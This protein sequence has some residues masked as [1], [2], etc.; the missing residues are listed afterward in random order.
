[1]QP[2]R[3]PMPLSEV[4]EKYIAAAGGYGKPAAL[5]SLG[6]SRAEVEQVFS[7]YDEDYHISRFFHFRNEA[8]ESYTINEFPQTHVTIDAEI[9]SI[10]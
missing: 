2:K 10:L 8:G 7:V 3:Q 5:S 1:M 4:V 6:F 9:Q